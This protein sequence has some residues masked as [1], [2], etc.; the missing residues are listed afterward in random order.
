MRTHAAT[1]ILV[2]LLMLLLS[3]L[4]CIVCS[5]A[6]L[7]LLLGQ[8]RS[9]RDSYETARAVAH[10]VTN[11]SI[12]TATS[13][14]S[15]RIM[16]TAERT[17]GPVGQDS[18]PVI[19]Q[20]PRPFSTPSAT[21]PPPSLTARTAAAGQTPT[22]TSARIVVPSVTTQPAPTTTP[23]ASATR[24]SPTAE[25]PTLTKGPVDTEDVI[26]EEMIAQQI[27]EDTG[28]PSL[29]DLSV[30]LT[31]SGFRAVGIVKTFPGIKTRV[32]AEGSFA[33][34]NHRL[35]AK[36]SSIK[37]NGLDVTGRYREPLESLVNLSLN[38]L[39][40]QRNVQSYELADGRIHVY[41]KVLP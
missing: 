29:S 37:L 38:R 22:A 21:I 27:L 34:E 36:I 35:V 39:L 2:V 16:G 15:V 28:D 41:S 32:Q 1:A 8:L 10:Q 13:V 20:S 31:A 5:C 17:K 23:E 12:R 26:T 3:I 11:D 9:E 4:P 19:G 6:S 18:S 25:Q 33:V 14:P 24:P 30:E 7:P 40:P